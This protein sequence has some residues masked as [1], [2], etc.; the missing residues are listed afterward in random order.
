MLGT[1]WKALCDGVTESIGSKRGSPE[2]YVKKAECFL[3]GPE[4]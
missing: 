4:I 1:K 2:D 3:S